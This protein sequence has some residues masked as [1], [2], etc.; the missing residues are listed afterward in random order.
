MTGLRLT[1]HG[2]QRTAAHRNQWVA[3]RL[4]DHAAGKH[5]DNP[6]TIWPDCRRA[7]ELEEASDSPA[8]PSM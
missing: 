2:R 3:I 8:A 1:E 4:A 5:A 7:N 6:S